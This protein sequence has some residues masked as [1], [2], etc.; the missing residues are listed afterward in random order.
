[1]KKIGYLALIILPLYA[2]VQASGIDV[3]SLEFLSLHK[4]T[5]QSQLKRSAKVARLEEANRKLKALKSDRNKVERESRLVRGVLKYEQQLLEGNFQPALD[6][7]APLFR[8]VEENFTKV[9][10]FRGRLISVCMTYFQNDL[11]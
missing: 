6:D 4:L 7:W 11:K 9:K 10:K 3:C 8:N 1:M 2:P 5:T